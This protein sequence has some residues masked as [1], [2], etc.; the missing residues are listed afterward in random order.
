MPFVQELRK[1]MARLNCLLEIS[2]K[3]ADSSRLI[4]WSR[5]WLREAGLEKALDDLTP[6]PSLGVAVVNLVQFGLF[7]AFWLR[8]WSMLTE[9]MQLWNP[10]A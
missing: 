10:V 4:A 9:L 5:T 8:Q 3:D 7:P 2:R 6:E 1:A